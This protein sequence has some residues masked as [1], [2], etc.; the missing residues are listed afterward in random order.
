M[1]SIPI[2]VRLLGH[3]ASQIVS[4]FSFWNSLNFKNHET[5]KTSKF[6]FGFASFFCPV[7]FET[8]KIGK[9]LLVNLLVFLSRGFGKLANF[10]EIKK[11]Y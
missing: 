6:R 5:K 3:H 11:T 7:V 2:E 8:S 1:F 9:S 4:W 10:Q